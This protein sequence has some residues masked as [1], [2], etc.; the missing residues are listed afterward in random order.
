[1]DG[2]KIQEIARQL[3]ESHGDK[4]RAEAAQKALQLENSGQDEEARNWRRIE[5]ALQEMQGPHSS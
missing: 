2:V 1:M 3:R 4:A 5:A